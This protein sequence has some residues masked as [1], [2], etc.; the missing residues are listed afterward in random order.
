M[1]TTIGLLFG[2]VLIASTTAAETRDP[3]RD[4]TPAITETASLQWIAFPDSRLELRGLP[5]F[6]ENAPELWRLPKSAKSFVPKGVW[7]R[8]IAPDGGR[9]RLAAATSRLVLR[10]DVPAGTGKPAVFDAYV[11]GEYAGSASLKGPK[12][13]ELVL[14]QG[15]DS[16]P[17]KITIHLPNVAEARVRAVGIDAGATLQPAPPFAAQAPLV[18]YGSSVLQGTGSAHPGTIYPAVIARRLNLDFVNLGFG[19]AGKAE[20]DVVALVASLDASCFLFDLG[21]SY[22]NQGREPFA[23]MLADIRAKHPTTPIVCVTP[24]YSTKEATEKGYREKSEDLRTLMRDAALERQA[25]G[26]R[27]VHVVEGL[28]LFGAADQDLFK[29]P[30]HPNDAGNERMGR[31]L[32]PLIEQLVLA[33]K[34]P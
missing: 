8:A 9:I 10:V 30:L 21:K 27:H 16:R 29:D 13:A 15:R 7:A 25:A 23:R 33:A 1:K 19:G 26:D 18:C 14:F 6:A 2:C 11:D 12:N 20:P 34:Q 4:A 3:D 31:R 28:T 24:I 5:W 32:V 17:K 22:G